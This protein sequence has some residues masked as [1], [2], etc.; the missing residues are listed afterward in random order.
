MV[1]CRDGIDAE[2]AQRLSGHGRVIGTIGVE[3]AGVDSVVHDRIVGIGD[4]LEARPGDDE[5]AVGGHAH[6]GCDLPVEGCLV[7]AELSCV[8]GH[9]GGAVAAGVDAITAAVLAHARP[10]DDVVPVGVQGHGRVDLLVERIGAGAELTAELC[11]RG[12]EPLAEN[13]PHVAVLLV[14]G[15]DDD[16]VADRIH[17]HV[18]VLLTTYRGRVDQEFVADR[19]ALDVETSGEDA[20][21]VAVLSVAGPGDDEVAVGVH[22]HFRHILDVDDGLIHEERVAHGIAGLVVDAGVDAPLV[23]V[24]LARPNDHEVPI[25]V[26]G[27]GGLGLDAVGGEYRVALGIEV[28]GVRRDAELQTL[29]LA[30]TV[31]PPHDDVAAVV[32]AVGGPD[33]DVVAVGIDGHRRVDPG[34][35]GIVDI[36]GCIGRAWF[37][38]PRRRSVAVTIVAA[39]TASNGERHDIISGRRRA[40]VGSIQSVAEEI[41]HGTENS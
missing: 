12:G 20:V 31:E 18:G 36:D 6:V 13:A 16:E 41:L 29:R 34:Q 40:G 33:D 7:D 10:D 30:V 23:L 37:G 1:A 3:H 9:P 25:G 4:V 8:L 27:Y 14:A 15:P 26:H 24:A 17:G 19:H 21:Q 38:I 35:V 22:G 32:V 39:A 5:V 11:A 28:A 2:L